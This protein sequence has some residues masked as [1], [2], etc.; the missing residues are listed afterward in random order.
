MRVADLLIKLTKRTF[1]SLNADHATSF[2]AAIAYYTL[3]SIFPI[4][5]FFISISGYFM[6]NHQRSDLVVRVATDLG[7][8][9]TTGIYSQ[10]QTA[11]NGRAGL[12]LIG[13]I[14]TLWAASAVFAAV[15]TGLD[16]VWHTPGRHGWLLTKAFDLLSV[17]ALGI[18]LAAALAATV[19]VTRLSAVA[20]HVLGSDLDGLTTFSFG[21]LLSLVPIGIVFFGFWLLYIM[22]S[23]EWIRWRHAAAGAGFAAVGFEL[24][25]LGFSL[26]VR[27]IGHFDKVYGSLGA[28]IAFLFYAYIVG[29]LILAGGE[30]TE[31]YMELR[32]PLGFREARARLTGTPVL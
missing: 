32:H 27:Y 26:Y 4:A 9:S 6:T 20:M 15:R 19:A 8:A 3:F 7:L 29:L 24:V 1:L 5:L 28:V 16:A 30:V 11:T 23:P 2:A 10:V 12:G 22:A 21:L 18:V 25:S 13:F 14:G 17:V 31:Q